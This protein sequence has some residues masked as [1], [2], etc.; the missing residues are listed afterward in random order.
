M[1]MPSMRTVESLPFARLGR[2]LMST[3]LLIGSA[4]LHA[5]STTAAVS[6]IVA[7]N[8][9]APNGGMVAGPGNMLYGT[10]WST[11]V[12]TGGL[13][14]RV[15]A[16]GSSIETL[17][18]L[19]NTEGYTPRAALLLA[20][21][22][23]LYGSTR[24][25]NVTEIATTGTVFRIATDGTGFTILH[26]FQTF[27]SSNVDGSP[28]NDDGAYP[29]AP[30]IEG[31]DGYLYGV[32]TAGGPNGTGAV[33]RMSR[34]GSDYSVLHS[35]GPL[36]VA[37][38]SGVSSNPDGAVATGAL[39]AGADGLL[40]GTA[41]QGGESGRGTVFRLGMDGSGFEV[42]HVFP[43]LSTD[44]SPATNASGAAPLSGLADGADGFLYG[45]A[46]VGGANGVGTVFAL[47]PNSRL[48]VVLHD[49]ESANGAQPA[50]ALILGS[51]TRLYG[52]TLY[53]GTAS[54]GST[55]NRG[56]IYSIAR[57]GTGFS[58]L[59]TFD[60]SQGTNPIGRLLETSDGFIGVTGTGGKCGQGTLFL[61]SPGGTT[62]E[63]N[64]KCGQKK[65][66]GG[67]AVPPGLLLLLGGL[68]LLRRWERA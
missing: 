36:S 40:Y 4:A 30:L 50:G 12:I 13:V 19:E 37:S 59:H 33:F 42:M 9:S 43:D 28:I 51:D 61:Y 31:P 24:L 15:A 25:G 3:M 54:D 53:G 38:T 8:A 32:T 45:T 35:F 55:V 11:S 48:L 65:N 26:R 29:E 2:L 66:N 22:G 6:T 52:T 17:H 63:G 64:T 14:Y 16:D 68:G 27:T 18:Q 57:D 67:G 23:L 5:Q 47:D 60:G 7:F 10:T 58:L 44:S 1:P 56:T 46:S 39:L 49:F 62:V 20:S 34:D 41:S 21:D